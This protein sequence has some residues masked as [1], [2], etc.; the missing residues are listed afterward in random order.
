[1]DSAELSARL[2]LR[3]LPGL[4]D[5]AIN[6]LI[7]EHGTA[8]AALGNS[9]HLLEVGAHTLADTAVR[10]R[11]NAALRAI[12]REKMRVLAPDL[13]GY[14]KCLLQRLEH[15]APALL[16]ALGDT[17]LL[18]LVSV[19]VVGSRRMSEYGR[20]IA[21]D[22]T[23]ELVRAGLCIISGLARG[24]D[25]TAHRA[26]LDAG[27]DTIAIVGNGANVTYPPDNAMLRQRIMH[28]GLIISQ[29]L[30]GDRPERHH[31]P[32]R[33]LVMAALA[34]GVLVVEAGAKSGAA[35]TARHAAD[36]GPDSMA[37]PGPIG[38]SANEGSNRLIRDGEAVCVTSVADILETMDRCGRREILARQIL[39]C[40]ARRRA[41]RAAGPAPHA[42]DQGHGDTDISNSNP[43]RGLT[44][45]GGLMPGGGLTPEADLVRQAL[46][47]EP[48]HLD[49]IVAATALKPGAVLAALLE[50]ELDGYARQHPGCRFELRAH[51]TAG[52][53]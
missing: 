35:I 53:G 12:D 19:A 5:R 29:F 42:L 48:R 25:A 21:E 11:V 36:L 24:I 1:M 10:T 33:N 17:R 44:P 41:R 30:P 26:A 47:C 16:F 51:V 28:E 15:A 46:S 40:E 14:P 50:L 2:T 31:F 52:A 23:R 9:T 18:P 13:P 38:R 27:G 32:E 34:E 43:G 49:E 8:A 4:R 20:T 39:D 6:R 37:I 3:S 7:A 45:G 22:F